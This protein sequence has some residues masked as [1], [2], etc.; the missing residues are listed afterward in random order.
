MV[1]L[2]S[3]MILFPFSDHSNSFGGFPLVR[4]HVRKY[5]L[6]S[7]NFDEVN[8]SPITG[9][10]SSEHRT[11]PNKRRTIGRRWENILKDFEKSLKISKGFNFNFWHFGLTRLDSAACNRF[12]HKHRNKAVFFK[13]I[14]QNFFEDRVQR[15]SHFFI[16]PSIKAIRGYKGCERYQLAHSWKFGNLQWR[17]F[18]QTYRSAQRRCSQAPYYW[19]NRIEE[20]W[21]IRRDDLFRCNLNRR[22]TNWSEF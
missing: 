20:H 18:S 2:S 10:S 6:L 14:T 3:G 17:F 1:T 11:L 19:F 21:L 5:F 8:N 15:K 12:P 22:Q 7:A 13:K 9:R 16:S 4:W